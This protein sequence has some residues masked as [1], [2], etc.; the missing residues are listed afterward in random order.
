MDEVVWEEL[1][2]EPT[3]QRYR[4]YKEVYTNFD[5]SLISSEERAKLD[6]IGENKTEFTY[7]EV[8]YQTFLPLLKLCQPKQG[9]VFW[10]IGCGGAKP[11]AIA[12]LEFPELGQCK[13]VEYLPGLCEQTKQNMVTLKTLADSSG[14]ASCCVS[15]VEGDILTTA[16]WDD[17]DIVYSSSVCFPDFLNDGIAELSRR[18]KTG[19]RLISLQPFNSETPWL[20]VLWTVKIKMTWG[21]H[22]ATI[23]LKL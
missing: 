11:L 9:E 13:G 18:L 15:I 4:I 16:W 7:G 8:M 22:P 3:L 5:A 10:D 20:E 2:P 1:F 12:A 6:E 23:Y 19:A 14:L 21:L 17:A